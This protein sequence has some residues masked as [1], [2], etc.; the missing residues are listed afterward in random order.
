MLAVG[1]DVSCLDILMPRRDF[2]RHIKIA[3]SDSP[4]VRAS[5]TNR[6]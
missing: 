1:A 3:T 6:V 5:V 4:S 2:G